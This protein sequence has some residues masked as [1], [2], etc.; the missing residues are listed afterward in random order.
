MGLTG[1]C[2]GAAVGAFVAGAFNVTVFEML[3]CPW[4]EAHATLIVTAPL[5][6]IIRVAEVVVGDRLL[7]QEPPEKAALVASN[8]YCW[9]DEELNEMQMD[10][11]AT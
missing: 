1:D 8:I 10:S 6:G 3:T 9:P 2:V 5:L 4:N 7:L 11:P